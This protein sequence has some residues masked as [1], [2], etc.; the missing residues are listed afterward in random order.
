MKRFL[1]LLAIGC[2]IVV[3]SANFSEARHRRR[4][5]VSAPYRYYVQPPLVVY[6]PVFTVPAPVV[7]HRPVYTIPVYRP[8]VQPVYVPHRVRYRYPEVE[9]KYKRTRYGYRIEY[10]ID[11]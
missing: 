3:A 11:D 4:V 5:Y 6:D 7:I 1:A 10:D 2:C 9:I 8:V